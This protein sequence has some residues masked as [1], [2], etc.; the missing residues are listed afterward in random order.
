M[1]YVAMD[2]GCMECGVS[3]SLIGVFLSKKAAEDACAA[4]E[5]LYDSTEW[6]DGGQAYTQIF[7][8][9]GIEDE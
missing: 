2:L 7:V 3:S 4:A 6:R 5:V 1:L 8:T 9:R